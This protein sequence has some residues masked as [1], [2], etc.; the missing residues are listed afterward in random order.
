[1][2][3]S[4]V[5]IKIVPPGS[6]F[7]FAE[8]SLQNLHGNTTFPFDFVYGSAGASAQ[9]RHYLDMESEE[10]KIRRFYTDR[11]LSSKS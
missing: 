2:P 8:R 4:R 6:D 5:S 3:D 9:I 11:N 1:M 10:K 7:G